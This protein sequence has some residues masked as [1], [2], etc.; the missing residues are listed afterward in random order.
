MRLILLHSDEFEWIPKKKAIK[1][2]EEIVKE[3]VS[4]DEALVVMI[5]V[6]TADE[7]NYEQAAQQTVDEINK[8]ADELEI[9]NVVLYPW[10]HLTSTPSRPDIALKVMKKIESTMN[11]EKRYKTLKR[12]PFG[13]YKGFTIKVK[14]HPLSELS[15][16]FSPGEKKLEKEVESKAIAAEE[17]A[18]HEFYVQLPS[19]DLIKR[20]EYNFKK[21]SSFEKF[22]E[23]ETQKRRASDSPPAHVELMQKLELVDYEPASDSGNLRWYPSGWIVKRL[24]EDHVT[25]VLVDHGAHCVE[26]PIM[27]DFHHPSLEAYMNRFPARQYTIK[28]GENDYFLRFAACF[29]QF[30]I[31]SD[32]IISYKHLPLKLFEMTHYS[33]R[34]E[35]RGELSALRRLRTFSMPDIHTLVANL[36]M[37]R[38]E[39]EAQFNICVQQMADYN[40]DYEAVFRFQS[41]FYEENKEWIASM[42]KSIDR[43]VMV[44]LFDKRYAYFICK[45]EFNVVDGQNKA[46]ALSTVQIDVENAERFNISYVNEA[47]ESV[48][49]YI[50]HASVSGAVERVVY[51][52]LEKAAAEIK[53]GIKPSLP[54]WLTPIQ[55]R[56]CP[57][58]D[59]QLQ[60]AEKLAKDLE[61]HHIR[62]DI[63]DRNERVGKKIR[64]A[65]KIWIPYVFVIGNNEVESNNLKA[66]T[67][68]GS[69]VEF[70]RKNVGKELSKLA[71]G[72]PVRPLAMAKYLSK[73]PTFY[74]LNK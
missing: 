26:T 54:F 29:G 52:I 25:N 61:N 46:A 19:G 4:V 42:I 5:S 37:A 38:E 56:L 14:G 64:D 71:S 10:V 65:E 73:R 34:R 55:V 33:F 59:D 47:G 1:A 12:A 18:K 70:T 74:S 68:D 27:Y 20:S 66:R 39:F 40:I 32:A 31:G 36:D 58:G 62:V 72:F 53:K 43:P 63:D 30:L 3:S 67:R 69:E 24:I 17:E 11:Q 23:Y 57:I 16:E 45:F 6:E 51:G 9:E 21:K 50:L 28:S 60:Y 8:V 49:P 15:R 35:Q 2:A 13:W 44:E 48:R 41:N 22:F 7:Q